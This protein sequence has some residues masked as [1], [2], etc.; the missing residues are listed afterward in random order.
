MPVMNGFE[1]MEQ[2]RAD[3][4]LKTIP[5]IVLTAERSAELQAL[6]IDQ[7]LSR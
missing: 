4:F 1:V 5:I 2:A 6:Q 3:E 7:P